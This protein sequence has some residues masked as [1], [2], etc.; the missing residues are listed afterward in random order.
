MP[1]QV[2]KMQSWRDYQ[3]GLIT[4]EELL[5]GKVFYQGDYYTRLLQK[6]NSF[7]LYGWVEKT[8]PKDENNLAPSDCEE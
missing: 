6:Y 5:E 1:A 8:K 4:K 3:S 2:I 7:D